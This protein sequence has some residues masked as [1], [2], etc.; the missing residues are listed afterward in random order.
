M[1]NK[2]NDEIADKAVDIVEQ[3]IADKEISEDQR[4]CYLDEVYKSLMEKE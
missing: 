1:S 2:I 3:L 4:D